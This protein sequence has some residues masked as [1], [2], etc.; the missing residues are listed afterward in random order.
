MGAAPTKQSAA[1][2][3][4]FSI[5][6]ENTLKPKAGDNVLVQTTGVGH[7]GVHLQLCLP[8]ILQKIFDRHSKAQVDY[9]DGRLMQV[10]TVIRPG[11]VASKRCA[12][13]EYPGIESN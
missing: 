4:P 9:R 13:F 5:P 12:T 11:P 3:K 2:T 8:R 10:A 6:H 7:V 1:P